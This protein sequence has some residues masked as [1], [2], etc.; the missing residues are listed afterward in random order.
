[1]LRPLRLRTAK[2]QECILPPPQF[3]AVGLADAVGDDACVLGDVAQERPHPT[4]ESV[5]AHRSGGGGACAKDTYLNAQFRRLATRRG[6]KKASVAV[7][8]PILVIVWHLLQ[9]DCEY[10]DLGTNYF[11]EHDRQQVARRLVKRLQGLG[12]RVA[13]DSLRSSASAP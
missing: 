13:L 8:H 9:H 10:F 4:R 1:V 6:A 5:A 7:A 11:D 12:F 3:A 2:R